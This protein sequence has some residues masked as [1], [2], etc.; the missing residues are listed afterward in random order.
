[1]HKYSKFS[2]TN[3]FFFSYS[4]FYD[5]IAKQNFDT[6]VEVG[7]WKGHSVS[8][9][10]KTNPGKSIYAVDLFDKSYQF[11]GKELDAQV[12]KVY[13]TY[14]DT[15][16]ST[17][18]R[19]LIEDIQGYSWE[20]ADKFEDSGVDFVFIDADHSYDAVVK[21]INAWYPKVRAGGIL[22]GHD[23]YPLMFEGV[24]KAVNEFTQS[25]GYELNVERG[26]VWW[27]TKKG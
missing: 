20:C 18:T 1:V 6:L 13:Q 10:A 12:P 8:Y 11:A 15:L 21:D 14:N 25:N 26:T 17:N 16:N 23:Y 2:G 24:V 4:K 3:E 7:V 9:L 19:E 22:A 5:F 27:I